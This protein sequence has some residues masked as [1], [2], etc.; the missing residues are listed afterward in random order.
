[1]NAIY[2][3]NNLPETE[4][5][6]IYGFNDGGDDRNLLGVLLSADGWFLGSHVCSSV[7]FMYS[8]LGIL[9]GTRP[10][11][12]EKFKEHYPNGYRME[13]LTDEVKIQS[14]REMNKKNGERKNGNGN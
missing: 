9:E 10:D 2:N 1:M 14:L 8:D 7:S 12:H 13:F 3:P 6:F 4:L 11:R 5:P